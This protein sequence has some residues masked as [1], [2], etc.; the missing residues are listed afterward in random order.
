ME[1]L[2]AR[3]RRLCGPLTCEVDKTLMKSLGIQLHLGNDTLTP[4]Y[5]L[6]HMITI[7]VPILI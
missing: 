4:R 1:N 7:V 3:S 2:Y 5:F 6:C